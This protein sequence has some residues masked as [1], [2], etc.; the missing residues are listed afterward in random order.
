MFLSPSLPWFRAVI[1]IIKD[2]DCVANLRFIVDEFDHGI[3]VV[4]DQY[5]HRE[6]IIS[7]EGQERVVVSFPIC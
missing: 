6:A 3:R 1:D 2:R 5:A 7:P 4:G